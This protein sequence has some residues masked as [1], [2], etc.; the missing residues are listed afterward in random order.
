MRAYVD[1]QHIF[2]KQQTGFWLISPLI[3]IFGLFATLIA[4]DCKI[5]GAE[6]T[7]SG[8]T[9]KA[10]SYSIICPVLSKVILQIV[11]FVI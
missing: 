8:K 7:G 2:F 10:N 4:T 9:E 6:F 1:T 5:A 3:I 11:Y